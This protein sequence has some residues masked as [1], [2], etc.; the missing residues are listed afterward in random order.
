MDRPAAAG[1]TARQRTKW[2]VVAAAATLCALTAAGGIDVSLLEHRLRHVRVSFPDGG[3]GQTWL[4]VGSDG[5]QHGAPGERADVILLVHTGAPHT[6]VISVPR[7]LLLTRTEGGVERAALTYAEGPQ[8]LIDGLCRTLGV[9]A[10][11][12]AIINRRGFKDAV[13]ALGGVTVHI[14]QRVRDRK[15]NLE[16]DE[17]GDVHL[18]GA[19]ALALVRSRHPQRLVDGTWVGVSEQVG[20]IKRAR[21]AAAV[22]NAIRSKAG[23]LRSNPIRLQGTLWAAT[24]DITL[25]A[26]SDLTD[27]LGLVHAHGRVTVLPAAR[28]PRTIALLAD[29]RTRSVLA[30]AGYPATCTPRG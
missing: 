23:A 4:L 20:A 17:T 2:I 19:Q 14:N 24:G 8:A 15:A 9:G 18:D 3:P 26:G 21:D 11:H 5:T 25:D 12:L 30:A 29:D 10:T 6:S 7:D 22:F 27:L 16:I 13:D 28:L 1:V